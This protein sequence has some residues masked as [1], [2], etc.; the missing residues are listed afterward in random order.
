MTCAVARCDVI[1]ACLF[2]SLGQVGV[3]VGWGGG[4]WGCWGKGCRR[5]GCSGYWAVAWCKVCVKCAYGI[6]VVV[7]KSAVIGRVSV[8][9]ACWLWSLFCGALLRPHSVFSD[10]VVAWSGWVSPWNSM[11]VACW[12]WSLFC[13][14]LLGPH[15]V[16]SD[17]V[18]V[19]CGGLVHGI[20]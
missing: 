13:G 20:V 17:Y 7:I 14:A 15:S 2:R 3:G 8:M 18:V 9:V 4:V 5:Y 12:L 19:W 6:E 11:M 10:Y 1:E 16:F